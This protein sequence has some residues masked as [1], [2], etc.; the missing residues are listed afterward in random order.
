MFMLSFNKDEKRDREKLEQLYQNY[1]RELYGVAYNILKNHHDAEDVIQ[2]A[3]IKIS[4]NLDKIID[5][6]CKKAR[7]YLV[8]VVRN[9]SFD[10]YNE[11]KRAVPTDF[12]DALEF[13]Q[14]GDFSLEKHVLRLEEGKELAEA[15]GK[16]N[17]TYAD[18]LTLKY[19][20]DY[21]N[22][23]IGELLNLSNEVVSLRLNRSK[24]AL[25]KI[26]ERKG[27]Q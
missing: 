27:G 15:L 20:Y 18:I 19:Y 9:L 10:R 6:N 7:G 3:F 2:T 23:E 4:K 1:S 26:L 17:P 13:E 11:K 21:S 22:T 16:I 12:S 25:R 24:A 14:E 8:I 5:V